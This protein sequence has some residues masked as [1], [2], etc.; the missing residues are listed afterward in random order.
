[1]LRRGVVLAKNSVSRNGLKIGD[2]VKKGQVIARTGKTGWTDRD[3]LHFIVF[4]L[5]NQIGNNHG[6]KSLKPKF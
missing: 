6:F 2:K 5:D 1:M 3:H 4:R